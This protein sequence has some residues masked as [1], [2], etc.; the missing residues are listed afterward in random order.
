MAASRYID[1]TRQAPCVYSWWSGHK[2]SL[3]IPGRECAA[4]SPK[5]MCRFF[6][7][8]IALHSPLIS[9]LS[10]L[11]SSQ[12]R[13]SGQYSIKFFYS[14]RMPKSRDLQSVLFLDRL[15][16]LF[17]RLR[18][19][20]R[21]GQYAPDLELE[22][23]VYFTG[24][25]PPEGEAF[26]DPILEGSGAYNEM[27]AHTRRFRHEELIDALGSEDKRKQTVAYVCGPP[28]MTD[29]VVEVLRK[30]GGMSKKS[31]LCEKWW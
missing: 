6:R 26:Q 7:V 31:V 12:K 23:N 2:V 25:T 27:T 15:A 3:L 16:T 19:L 28:S 1:N 9:I 20:Q 24:I 17:S 11:A 21:K 22:L 29:E 8:L 5:P 30:A 18:D 10:H 13:Q 4:D 14:C